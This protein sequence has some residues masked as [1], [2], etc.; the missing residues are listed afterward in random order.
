VIPIRDDNPTEITPVVTYA[1]LAV[2]VAVFL[3]TLGAHRDA[4]WQLG[5]VPWELLRGQVHPDSALLGAL[6]ALLTS[7]F[8]H[9]GFLHLGGNMLFL[10]VF[11]NNIE[12]AMG[13]VKFALFYVLTGLIAHAFHIGSIWVADGPPPADPI[14]HDML[15]HALRAGAPGVGWFV[16]TVGASGAI[17]GILAAYFV[18]YP[19]AR[20]YMLVPIGFFITT[21]VISAA[22]AIGYWFV[23]QLLSGVF[24]AGAGSGVAFWAHIGGFVGGYA[25]YRPFLRRRFQHY[26]QLQ[27]RWRAFQKQ[28]RRRGP[29]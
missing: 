3:L 22:F 8:M 1:L 23:I 2:N 29:F 4:V 5:F 27:Q 6:P 15:Q 19:R 13:H 9:G 25:I 21:I 26:R 11:G 20:V 14:P 28:Q 18:L 12:D 24:A 16:P 10:W 17:S 7:M